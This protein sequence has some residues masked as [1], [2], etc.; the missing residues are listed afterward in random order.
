MLDGNAG[1]TPLLEETG[2]AP[3]IFP[4]QKVGSVPEGTIARHVLGTNKEFT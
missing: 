1:I 2:I 3:C 4:A